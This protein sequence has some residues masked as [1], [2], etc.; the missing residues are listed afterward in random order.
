MRPRP[1]DSGAVDAVP[2]NVR[3]AH[4]ADVVGSDAL[5]HRAGR[6]A[7]ERR[8]V[9]R[10]AVDTGGDGDD[11]HGVAR[12]LVHGS[13]GVRPDGVAH[14]APRDAFDMAAGVADG[15]PTRVVPRAV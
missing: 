1:V 3:R 11:S 9:R 6:M 13:G 10:G 5:A 14:G 2:Q 8:T 4:G 15:G 7:A 12:G